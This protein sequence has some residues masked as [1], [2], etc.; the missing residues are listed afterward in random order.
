MRALFIFYEETN[1]KINTDAYSKLN[2]S[3]QPGLF[4]TEKEAE[5]VKQGNTTAVSFTKSVGERNCGA[6][7]YK[8]GVQNLEDAAANELDEE[9]QKQEKYLLAMEHA[10]TPEQMGALAEQGV[11]VD[12]Y[13]PDESIT[14]LDEIKIALAKGG[15]DI[16]GLTDDVD[17]EVLA[18]VLSSVGFAGALASDMENVPS[19]QELLPD[20]EYVQALEEPLSESGKVYMVRNSLA[21]TPENIF[22][23]K[24]SAGTYVEKNLTDVS[25]MDNLEE[26]MDKI[27]VECGFA[28]TPE[29]REEAAWLFEN[30]LP[31][32]RETLLSLQRIEQV[33]DRM[34]PDE[35]ASVLE[36]HVQEGEEVTKVDLSVA[37]T[38]PEKA[39]RIEAEVAQ[40]EEA[41]I[42]YAVAE[43]KDEPLT[44]RDVLPGEPVKEKRE[45]RADKPV[46]DSS[47]IA[48][49]PAFITAR[50]QLEEV[51]LHMSAKANLL[52]LQ[53]GIS[54][55]TKP[56]E[57]LIALLKEAEADFV[58][59]G[60]EALFDT[61]Q[62]V[63]E[64]KTYPASTL[65]AALAR[66]IPFTLEGLHTKGKELSAD[67]KKAGDAYETMQTEVRPDLGD[68]VKKAFRNTDELLADMNREPSEENRRAVRILGYNRL[69]LSEENMER[70]LQADATLQS[71]FS[72]MKPGKVLS[73]IRE[74]VN[75]LSMNLED[76]NRYLQEDTESFAESAD[77]FAAFLQK[78]DAR[79]DITQE[80]RESFIGIYRL[81]RQVEKT[82]GAALGFL[83]GAESELTLEN[84]LLA[85]RSGQRSFLDYRIDESFAGRDRVLTGKDILTQVESAFASGEEAALLENVGIE[86]TVSDLGSAKAVLGK[87]APFFREAEQRVPE[88]FKSFEEQIA[89]AIVDEEHMQEATQEF[90]QQAEAALKEALYAEDNTV[91]DVRKLRNMHRQLSLF[92][93]LAEE[94]F[95]RIPFA[96]KDGRGVM[97]LH[98]KK[99]G[100][101]P[102]AEISAEFAERHVEARFFL[103]NGAWK[104]EL[105]AGDRDTLVSLQGLEEMFLEGAAASGINL[106][107][108]SYGIG[109]LQPEAIALPEDM[110][111]TVSTEELYK[112]SK[113]FLESI[114]NI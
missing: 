54:I 9:E 86:A 78:L 80:E 44:L 18:A 77:K 10:G 73:M 12:E 21:P 15:A 111:M 97:N 85:V 70:A 112:V 68:S 62:T 107:D 88:L 19:L 76:L 65:S 7:A 39:L 90:V 71:V 101:T 23:A 58:R 105:R 55:D 26:Q 79:G 11:S 30:D 36:K 40:I 41:D 48:E 20:K 59:S 72:N 63:E 14:I 75:P 28:L 25:E 114:R 57:E 33:S 34:T 103:A 56:M 61:L 99:T 1:L 92:G 16:A 47:L 74:G 64:V 42:A 29:H 51:R 87:D 93:K 5:A 109:K 91:L 106:T 8:K 52:L 102:S 60:A 82:D 46:E 4:K 13:T 67:Y 6:G 17:K 53:R 83:L 24:Y 32:T 94:Q 27:L 100:E 45:E 22:K 89:D 35:M 104:G 3:L 81:S 38:L 108:V 84:L 43:K 50:R 37:E 110:Q 31:I 113:I 49:T 95:F 96:A 69:A 2:E 98:V 66:E